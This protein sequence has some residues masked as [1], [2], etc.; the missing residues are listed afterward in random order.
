MSKMAPA[1]QPIAIPATAPLLRPKYAA[2]FGSDEAVDTG[3]VYEGTASAL[4][5]ASPGAPF[6]VACFCKLA[7]NAPATIAALRED[8]N[9]VNASLT[10]E[11]PIDTILGTDTTYATEIFELHKQI[12][13]KRHSP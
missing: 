2:D 12:I 10:V 8:D 4:A 11:K 9:P 6:C 13:I 3:G 7:V 1:M 5:V